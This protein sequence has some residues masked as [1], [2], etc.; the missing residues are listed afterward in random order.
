M[1]RDLKPCLCCNGR[2]T[3]RVRDLSCPETFFGEE[4]PMKDSK[5]HG[6]NGTGKVPNSAQWDDPEVGPA[7]KDHA[8]GDAS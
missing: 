8:S 6:C 2:G 3:V 1:Y 7:D 4:W 5:C